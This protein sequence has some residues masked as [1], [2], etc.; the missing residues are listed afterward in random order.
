MVL[1]A[2]LIFGAGAWLQGEVEAERDMLRR[3]LAAG[4]PAATSIETFSP[5]EETGLAGEVR[6]EAQLDLSLAEP[7]TLAGKSAEEHALMVPLL[8]ADA[9][10]IEARYREVLAY[11]RTTGLVLPEDELR[12]RA[13]AA[14]MPAAVGVALIEPAEGED[15]AALDPAWLAAYATG[16]G[17]FGPLVVINGTLGAGERFRPA[18]SAAF[19]E[20]G[21]SLASDF[22]LVEPYRGGREA[23]LSARL[24]EAQDVAAVFNLAA[25]ALVML[26]GLTGLRQRRRRAAESIVPVP[27]DVAERPQPAA[28]EKPAAA[29]E[30]VPLWK[31]RMSGSAH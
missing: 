29:P 24:G 5:A 20:Q 2:A 14:A 10:P 31:A 19:D 22:L 9:P 3:A 27:A 21:R 8:A 28:D 11:M 26:A 7:V 13:R 16:N 25:G 6:L 15:V 12:Q 17:R 30:G 4:P 18:I 1:S 23:A